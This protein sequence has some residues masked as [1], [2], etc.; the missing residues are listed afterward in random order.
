MPIGMV[1]HHSSKNRK[2]FKTAS[3]ISEKWFLCLKGTKEE[4][5]SQPGNNIA[6]AWASSC[7][8]CVNVS[9]TWPLMPTFVLS[10]L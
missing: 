3:H 1:A 4:K 5:F 2:K 10:G 7:T 8:S 9:K 6:L